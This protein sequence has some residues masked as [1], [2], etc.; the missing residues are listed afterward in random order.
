MKPLYRPLALSF[1]IQTICFSICALIGHRVFDENIT[2]W[3]PSIIIALLLSFICFNCIK[4][5]NFLFT[6]E[7]LLTTGLLWLTTTCIG[8]LPYLL[9]ADCDFSTAFFESASGLTTTGASAINHIEQ[10]PHSLLLWRALSQW[11]GGLGL[12]IFFIPFLNHNDN[13]NKKLFLQETSFSDDSITLFNLRKNIISALAMYLLLTIVC[14]L[15]LIYFKIPYFDAFCHTLSTVSTGGFS[16]YTGGLPSLHNVSVENISMIFMFLGGINFLFLA[17][18]FTAKGPSFIFNQEFRTYIFLISL[19]IC[20]FTFLLIKNNLFS[21]YEAI[22]HAAFQAISIITTTGLHSCNYSTWPSFAL[23]LILIL[24]FIGGCSGSTSGGFKI[25]RITALFK[26]IT[27]QFEKVFHPSI[28]RS[29]RVNKILLPENK[30]ME[31][32]HFFIISI[33]I[34]FIG[35]LSIQALMPSIDILTATSTTIACLSNV[36][37]GIT[38]AI[39]PNENFAQFTPSVKLILAT[40]MLLGRLEIYA[41][42]ALFSRKFWKNFE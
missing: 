40:I 22:H 10:I 11:L 3:I 5:K 33:F 12:V 34:I 7:I 16:I 9:I 8:T 26:I 23:T 14:F 1:F 18:I 37:P 30:Q 38:S 2:D 17:Q 31:L 21:T 4:P 15:S 27:T 32:L 25:F 35:T 41:I 13:S 29:V 42:L 39:G 20:I 24:T 19:S 6:R 36:G 28:I